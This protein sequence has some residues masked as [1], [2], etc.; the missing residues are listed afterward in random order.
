LVGLTGVSGAK[1]VVITLEL[2]LTRLKPVIGG[3][4]FRGLGFQVFYHFK[5]LRFTRGEKEVNRA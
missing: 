3:L 1:P 5:R 2:V 4:F